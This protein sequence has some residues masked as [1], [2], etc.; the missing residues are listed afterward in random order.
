MK[1][2]KAPRARIKFERLLRKIGYRKREPYNSYSKKF[3]HKILEDC[4]P[5]IIDI[6]VYSIRYTNKKSFLYQE[7]LKDKH[8]SNSELYR[9]YKYLDTLGSVQKNCFYFR[10]HIIHMALELL[11]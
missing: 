2:I 9:K 3:T 6:N 5:D 11:L 1:V 4:Y 8:L 10:S 7:F